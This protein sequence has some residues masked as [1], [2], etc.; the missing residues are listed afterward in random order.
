ML[1]LPNLLM[2]NAFPPGREGPSRIGRPDA[3]KGEIVAAKPAAKS[4]TQNGQDP[5]VASGFVVPSFDALSSCF[6]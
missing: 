3:M 6:A 5:A 2:R 1:R 4:S